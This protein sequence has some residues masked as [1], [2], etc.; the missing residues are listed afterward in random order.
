MK[1]ESKNTQRE[2]HQINKILPFISVKT[3]TKIRLF[4]AGKV[5]TH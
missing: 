5:K 2:K 4:A 3:K 1:E